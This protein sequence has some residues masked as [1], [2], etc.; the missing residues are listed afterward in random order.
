MVSP[1]TNNAVNNRGN[2]EP[3]IDSAH[4]RVREALH[5]LP[6]ATCPVGFEFRL[7]RRLAGKPVGGTR[8]GWNMNWLGAGIGF[9][10]AMVLAVF[11][12]DFGSIP[13]TTSSGMIPTATKSGVSIE[14]P[15]TI[16]TSTEQP[17]SVAQEKNAATATEQLAS[18]PD[19][20]KDKTK[21][22]SLPDGNY[23]TVGGNGGR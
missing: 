5:S 4:M 19:S 14:Q 21:P 17:A 18:T 3:E 8:S 15:A 16:T 7:E 10:T 11:I 2:M 1:D 20:M 6:K 12:F 13:G 9:A 22:G 23:Q